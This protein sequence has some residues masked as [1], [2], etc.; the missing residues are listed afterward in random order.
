MTLNLSNSFTTSRSRGA[1]AV[2]FPLIVFSVMMLLPGIGWGQIAAVRLPSQQRNDLLNGL[3]V[4]VVERPGQVN[5]SAVM[6]TFAGAA[7]DEFGKSGTAWLTAKML[8]A[9]TP[10]RTS[11][12]IAEDLSAEGLQ[13]Q[14]Y[15]DDD[16]SW[17]RLSGPAKDIHTILE[18]MSDLLLNSNFNAKELDQ[19]KE[20]TVSDLMARRQDAEQWA[21]LYFHEKLFGLQSYGPPPEGTAH[22]IEAITAA[23]CAQFYQRFYH[24]NNA[25]LLVVGGVETDDVV[26]RVRVL[27]GGWE[28]S[29]VPPIFPKAAKQPVGIHIRIGD[30]PGSNTAVIRLGRL[31]PQRTSRDYYRLEMMNCILGGKGFDSLLAER[32]LKK[33]HL[34]TS[35][36]SEF[37]YYIAGGD[38]KVSVTTSAANAAAAV[39][40][41]LDEIKKIRDTPVTDKQ[42]AAASAALRERLVA[43]AQTN[44]Q[45]ADAWAQIE[46]YNLAF[47]ALSA[48][49]A[50]LNRVTAGDVQEVAHA[51]LDPDS[52]VLVVIG[53]SNKLKAALQK[54]GPVEVFPGK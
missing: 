11:A 30:R 32:L 7:A 14:A 50:H 53:D 45:I 27:F 13:A 1:A 54:F 10:Q 19:L 4:V 5:A 29:P 25:M 46:I 28:N 20:K 48:Y 12:Q 49:T 18:E 47:D 37:D 3:K 36:S 2:M 34:A 22:T 16:A 42:L 23:D 41:A 40:D 35:V 15:A 21:D 31:G 9:S 52:L 33:D 26:N 44:D 8:L 24:P 51:Y 38:W 39:G 17:F 6:V 43:H